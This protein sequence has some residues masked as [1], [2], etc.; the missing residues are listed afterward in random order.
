M[1]ACFYRV[2]R[3]WFALALT[4]A[5]ILPADDSDRKAAR[6]E[7]KASAVAS[8]SELRGRIVCLAEAM[9]ELYGTDLPTGH[10]HLY[11]FRTQG[12]DFYT[13]L[14]TKWSE[15]LFVDERMRSK[16]LILIGRVLPG[17]RIFD[18]SALRSVKDNKVYDLYYYC[19]VCAIRTLMPGP[20]MCCREPVELV[21]KPLEQSSRE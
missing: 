15:G 14:R 8:Q 17:T 7:S 2:P 6:E 4:P 16:E 12:G 11:G 21:E 20:C 19:E 5:L 3:V 13:L 10:P 18:L 1:K 9:H